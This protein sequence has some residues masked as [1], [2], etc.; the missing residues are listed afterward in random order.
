M[1]ITSIVKRG[2]SEKEGPFV[3]TLDTALQSIGV[4][5]FGG[6]FIGN[7][8]HKALKVQ[9]AISMHVYRNNS[10]GSNLSGT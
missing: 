10:H 4:Q 1:R 5:Y 9:G 2:Y 8:I 3:M 7:H 6:A